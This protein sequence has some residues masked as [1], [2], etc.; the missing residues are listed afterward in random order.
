MKV[1]ARSLV[2]FVVIIKMSREK[3][4][5]TFG[6]QCLGLTHRTLAC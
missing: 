1:W 5:N 4:R 3:L 2:L 6:E